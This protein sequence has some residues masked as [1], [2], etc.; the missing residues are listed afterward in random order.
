MNSFYD[1]IWIGLINCLRGP[2]FVCRALTVRGPLTWPPAS[3]VLNV[4]AIGT[5]PKPVV[6]KIGSLFQADRNAELHG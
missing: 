3:V 2:A 4:I 6:M 5:E 1:I